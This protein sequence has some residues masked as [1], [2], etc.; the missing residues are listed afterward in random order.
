MKL[1]AILVFATLI[2]IS[3]LHAYWAFG[4]L[5][6]AKTEQALANTVI[7][8]PNI[9]GMPS[10][11]STLVVAFLI[12]LTGF[13]ALAAGG[14]IGVAPRWFA[15]IIA[16]GAGLVFIARGVAGYFFETVAWTPVEPF[17]TLNRL[18]YSPLCLFIGA[19]FFLLVFSSN[20]IAKGTAS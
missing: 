4:G 1:L 20:Q 19:A 14:I 7:G 6:P 5:W 3:A 16:A 2:V 15:Q 9:T 11:G 13:I 8:A 18:Y 12:L 10:T 17:A